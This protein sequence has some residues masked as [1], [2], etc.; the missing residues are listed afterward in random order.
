LWICTHKDKSKVKS[1]KSKVK[2]KT[3][4]YKRTD[5]MAKIKHA[6]VEDAI[7]DLKAGK[8][9]IVVDDEDRENEGDLICVA[10][11]ITPEKITFMAKQGSGLICLALPHEQVHRLNL[12]P[13]APKRDFLRGSGADDKACGVC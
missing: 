1:Q 7:E 2:Q 13:M 3:G 12:E 11:K 6:A 4:K 5:K 9:I 10:E 8:M